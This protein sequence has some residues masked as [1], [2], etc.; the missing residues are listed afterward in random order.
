MGFHERLERSNPDPGGRRWLF[1][2]EDQLSDEIGPLSREPGHELGIVLIESR[3]K[4]ARRPYH[5]QR[6]LT[7]WA[8]QRHFA[9]EQAE[10]GV[11]VRYLRADEPFA[12][13]LARLSAELGPLRAME[14]AERELRADLA[15]LVESASLEILDHEGWITTRDD[16]VD[17][18]G[19]EPPW[20]MDRFY[21]QVR[22][23]TGLLMED[24]APVGGKYSFDAE[25]REPWKGEPEAPTPATFPRDAIKE[26]VAATIE[27][28]FAHH[29]GTLDLDTVAATRDDAEAAWRWAR[30]W[31]LPS[32][33][34]YEDAMSRRSSTLF[35][36]RL[37]TLLNLHRLLPRRVVEE[38][39]AM[40]VPLAGK[41]GFVRQVLGWREFVR[42]VH[43][44]TDGFRDLPDAEVDVA[45]RPGDGGYA[46]WKGEA[47]SRSGH[48]LDPDGGA[49][50]DHLG[51]SAPLVP[52]YWGRRSG[53]QC[54]DHVV[55]DVWREGWSHHITRL[56]VLSNLA[57][58]LDLSPR[59]LTD[60][61]WV[62][63]T[64]A[65]DWV[66][67]P[68][69]LAMGTY[70]TGD[71]MTTK[72]YVSGTPYL[73]RMSDYCES[74]AF[75]PRSNCPISALYWAFLDR[76]HDRLEGNHRLAMPLRTLERRGEERRE[77]DRRTFEIVRARLRAGEELSPEVLAE[78]ME[79]A[80]R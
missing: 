68:N 33:G 8:N 36:T 32:F 78:A 74:C 71:L 11:A 35:H 14:P 5:R 38:A 16:F 69:V 46:Q 72:P 44:E 55:E 75:D 7:L 61:F 2:P 21:R 59:D 15:P 63:Y 34:P 56:M 64:D 1:V 25:N 24:G 43:R 48:A 41:E 49:R 45:A 31:A 28:E 67:E 26:E 73:H 18:C 17:G 76:H 80:S 53:L 54:L 3:W 29:P 79:E 62:A 51:S 66:V 50:P 40:D 10:R 4:A 19:E 20:R 47:W 70:A 77:D 65:W 57:T 13:V 37:S 27:E 12:V 42:H 52:A 6:L 58:L 30:E 39:A 9:L 60:W 23:R 22:R